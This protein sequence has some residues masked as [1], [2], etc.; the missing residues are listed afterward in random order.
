M[1]RTIHSSDPKGGSQTV[2]STDVH[3]VNITDQHISQRDSS[4]GGQEMTHLN[5][6]VVSYGI[7][8]HPYTF[9]LFIIIIKFAYFIHI[10]IYSYVSHSASGAWCNI[11]VS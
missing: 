8:S 11:V 5:S 2:V 9:S 7:N 10:Y 4:H 6:I 1:T 3:C